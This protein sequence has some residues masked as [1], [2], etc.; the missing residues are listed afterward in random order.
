MEA[1]SRPPARRTLT[2]AVLLAA[3][4]TVA[5][6]GVS[7]A[8]VAGRGGLQLPGRSASPGP[9]AA[10]TATPAAGPSASPAPAAT[11]AAGPSL[12]PLPSPS[13]PLATPGEPTPAPSLDPLAVLPGCPDHPGCYLYTVKR[14][15]SLSTI[16][17]HWL[18]GLWILEALN[19]EVADPG[20]IVV[21]QTIYLGRSP[22]VR[23]DH[24]PDTPGCYLY[25][26]RSGDTLSTIAGRFG[27]STAAIL[28]LNP[29][30][31][32]ANT[33]HTGQTIRLPGP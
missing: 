22:V 27:T 12:E 21:G 9:I 2:P 30:I 20:T 6:A 19:P 5:C 25:E 31:T 32:D 23:L 7:I 8:F 1:P 10:A 24:C 11:P 3:L 17:D 16:G 14:G 33:I 29:T 18:I 28:D 26:V 4:F 15:D 13:A